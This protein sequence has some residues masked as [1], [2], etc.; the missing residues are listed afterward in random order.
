LGKENIFM[1]KFIKEELT[2]S[3]LTIL[4][5]ALGILLAV[6]GKDAWAAIVTAVFPTIKK[7]SLASALLLSLGVNLVLFGYFV[8]SRAGTKRLKKNL[9]FVAEVGIW[10]HKKTGLHYCPSCLN[11]GIES[12]LQEQSDRFYCPQKDCARLA[13]KSNYRAAMLA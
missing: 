7:E 11:R 8:W 13:Y 5:S 12:L 3:V 10:R 4:L 1:L 2:R 9:E 6:I